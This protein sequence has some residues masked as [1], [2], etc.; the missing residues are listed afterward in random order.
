ML[1][2]IWRRGA[3]GWDIE[4]LSILA[5]ALWGSV[6]PRSLRLVLSSLISARD[7][8]VRHRFCDGQALA[9]RPTLEPARHR[10]TGAADPLPSLPVE[11]R[12]A[13]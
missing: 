9:R 2:Q 1:G 12:P 6:S 4:S 13:A 3:L 8:T 5:W 11:A 10:T 7:C